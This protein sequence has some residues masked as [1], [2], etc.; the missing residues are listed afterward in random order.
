MVDAGG[1]VGGDETIDVDTV[2]GRTSR[3]YFNQ[4][5]GEC[6]GVVPKKQF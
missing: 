2:M 5:P 3:R 6:H 1:I 4:T